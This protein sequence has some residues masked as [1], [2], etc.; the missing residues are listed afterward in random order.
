MCV[1]GVPGLRDKGYRSPRREAR[2]LFG[3]RRE[4]LRSKL[5]VE[6]CCGGLRLGIAMSRGSRSQG[7]SFR[8]ACGNL[9]PKR[10]EMASHLRRERRP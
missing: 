10:H 5:A 6:A 3:L 2:R 7:Q 9:G 1:L 4:G 8:G